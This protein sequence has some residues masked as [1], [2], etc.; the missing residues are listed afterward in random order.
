MGVN[1]RQ[2]PTGSGVWWVFINHHGVRKSK[3]IGKDK[4]LAKQWQKNLEAKILL[5]DLDMATFNQVCPRFDD[6]ANKWLAL[7]LPDKRGERTQGKYAFN[8]KTHIYPVIGKMELKNIELSDMESLFNGLRIQG[9]AESNFQNIKAP[10]NHIFVQAMRD[11]IIK[12]NPLIGLTKFSSKRSLKIEPLTDE[13]AFIFLD[14]VREYRDGLFY[15]HFL[16]LLRTGVRISEL[17]GLKWDDLDFDKRTLTVQRQVYQG[18]EGATKN[19]LSRVIDMTQ[20]LSETLKALQ[21]ERKKEAFK[22]GIPFCDWVFTFNGRDSITATPIQK[23]LKA[24]LKKAGLHHQRIHD[25]RHSYATIRLMRG[26][27]IGDVS[28][29]M[30]HSSIKITFDTYTNWIPGKFHHEVDDLD[31][32]ANHGKKGA[33]REQNGG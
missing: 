4:K 6:Y 7:P 8:L 5:N 10:I 28:Y 11:K 32:V 33:N 18:T 3:K 15:P 27:N 29:Q 26:H 19:G 14:A 13:E 25:L 24:C 9:M 21:H 31:M 16:I 1:I 12:S 23:S 17:C 30:G 22:S 20:H 2:K